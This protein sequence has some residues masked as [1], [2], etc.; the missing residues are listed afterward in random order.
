MTSSK[1]T[2]LA[3]LPSSLDENVPTPVSLYIH[4][5]FCTSKCPYCDFNS[6]VSQHIEEKKW[7]KAYE[8]ALISA[9]QLMP[10]PPPLRTIFF[11][12]GTPSLMSPGLVKH[13]LDGAK[14]VW[15]FSPNIE[16]TLEANPGSLLASHLEGYLQAGVNRLSIGI[17]SFCEEGLSFLGR[18]H[19]VVQ[20][21]EAISLARSM[22]CN[23]SIDLIY[24][25]P[26]HSLSQWEKELH[27]ALAYELPHYS[28]YQ[29]T[30]EPTTP[31]F[32]AHRKGSFTM[33]DD[34]KSRTFY[35][36]THKILA[37]H[38]LP[39]YEVS[40]FARPGF[41]C[42]HNQNYWWYHNFIGVGPGAHGRIRGGTDT[43]ATTQ[44]KAPT[45]WL[46]TALTAPNTLMRST[47]LTPSEIFAE[48][49]LMALRLNQGIPY[50]HLAPQGKETFWATLGLHKEKT[51][52][53]EGYISSNKEVLE[54]T[55]EGRLRLN[56][57]LTYLLSDLE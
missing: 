22:L 42:Q 51:L 10:T 55:W 34:E 29:L 25:H 45:K 47:P 57:I 19:S 12:G 7:Q 56:S 39:S 9:A 23:L 40:N 13:V 5:P 41:Q 49:T 35:T 48:K 53:K 26:K 43:Y 44:H 6:H 1:A 50:I 3:P 17:Q 14:Q 38:G 21:K 54:L 18:G 15:G 36:H 11:G 2:K 31:F 27:E 37:A 8:N 28:L 30:I 24:A 32:H 20:G 4:W 52:A 46:D 16:I 33:P